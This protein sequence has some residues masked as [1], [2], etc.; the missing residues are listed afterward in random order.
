MK[1]RQDFDERS[2]EDLILKNP[3]IIE[4][5]LIILGNQVSVNEKCKVDILAIDKEKK[6]CIIEIKTKKNIWK[7]RTG[8]TQL[9]QYE[10]PIKSFFENISKALGLPEFEIRKILVYPKIE[11]YHQDC[12]KIRC[13]YCKKDI[14][15]GKLAINFEVKE[16]EL[17]VC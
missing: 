15:Y 4:D 8:I 7:V 2:L 10:P 12:S 5:G 1:K 11:I 3:S 17:K 13:G 16:M 9:K 14:I 6:I